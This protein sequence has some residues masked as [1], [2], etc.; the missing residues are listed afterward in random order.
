[1]CGAEADS[2]EHTFKAS[3][4]RQFYRG[5]WNQQK[6]KAWPF[7][8]KDGTY[9]QLRGPNANQLKYR[10][11]LC[12]KCNS[13]KS[14]HWDA[15]YDRL[16]EWFT[17]Q[18]AKDATAADL[19]VVLGPDVETQVRNLHKY[20]A[21]ALGCRFVEATGAAPANFPNPLNDGGFGRLLVSICR[22]RGLDKYTPRM[23]SRILGKG[24]LLANLASQGTGL[25]ESV[26]NCLWWENVGYFQ[27]S[28]WFEIEPDRQF[29]DILDG[30]RSTYHIVDCPS[31][32]LKKTEKIMRAWLNSHRTD[33]P[34][35]Y[36][37][38]TG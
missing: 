20:F 3:T 1:M 24:P 33:E 9:S 12:V 18:E 26:R 32:N 8:F 4:L 14:S 21:K 13:N 19:S 2:S 10:N 25:G 7:H 29:G 28:Y 36:S 5:D 30:R 38:P 27:I 37:M 22:L 35:G 17:S 16:C 6:P 15:A 11:T 31:M 34:K 23:G